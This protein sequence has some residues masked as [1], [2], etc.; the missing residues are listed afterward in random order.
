MPALDGYSVEI[1][2]T[3]VKSQET[4][5]EVLKNRLMR[6]FDSTADANLPFQATPSPRLQSRLKM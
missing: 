5:S 1:D 4:I 2:S 3:D 6:I